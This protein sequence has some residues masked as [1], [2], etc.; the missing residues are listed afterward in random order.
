[1][2][3]LRG[4]VAG[5]AYCLLVAAALVTDG[6]FSTA[7]AVGFLLLYNT[8]TLLPRPQQAVTKIKTFLY[9]VSVLLVALVAAAE[10][11]MQLLRL[12]KPELL[13]ESEWFILGATDLKQGDGTGIAALVLCILTALVLPMHA[14]CCGLG[15]AGDGQQRPVLPDQHKG[16][17][18]HL[19]MAFLLLLLMVCTAVFH[20]TTLGFPLLAATLASLVHWR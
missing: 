17:R 10:P 13:T 1:M 9:K 15:P 16:L 18:R 14:T 2:A 3:A 8:G 6:A 12:K 7:L 5:S 20:I 11:C 19:L 4:F